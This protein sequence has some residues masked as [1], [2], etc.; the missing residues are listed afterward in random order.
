MTPLLTNENTFYSAERGVN[1]PAY[2]NILTRKR[3]IA[4][5]PPTQ[6]RKLAAILW[7]P[8]SQ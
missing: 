7:L 3:A 4:L 1:D 6:I 5:G 2:T 8:M